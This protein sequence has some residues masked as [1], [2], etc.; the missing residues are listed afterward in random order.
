MD[1]NNF[2]K[3]ELQILHLIIDGYNNKEIGQKLNLSPHTIKCRISQIIAKT[4]ARNRT[5]L[6]FLIGSLG[7]LPT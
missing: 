2:S 6:A 1:I 7:N 5:H 3:R 4:G